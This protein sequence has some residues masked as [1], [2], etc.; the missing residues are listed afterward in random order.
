MHARVL[1]L[2]ACG[3]GAFVVPAP[4][5]SRA[6][7][8]RL[9]APASVHGPQPLRAAALAEEL[10]LKSWCESNGVVADK[11]AF[12]DGAATATQ[13]VAAL[14]VLARVPRSLALSVPRRRDWAG[15]LTAEA[16]EAVEAGGPLASYV[17]SWRGGGWA[18]SSEDL[19]SRDRDTVDCLLATGSDNDFEI[20]KKFG[21]KCHPAV[22]R[23]AYRLAAICRHPDEK[24][25]RVAQYWND[26]P[27]VMR[28]HCED[29]DARLEAVVLGR[30]PGP[31]PPW[32]SLIGRAQG[33]W[34][35]G[36]IL[37]TT[38]GR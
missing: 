11:L 8:R 9:L 3:A 6:R 24:A 10:D 37:E 36:G 29:C 28:A 21:M 38:G 12:D 7:P 4:A 16:I 23:A 34:W 2:I 15:A 32:S 26:L 25:A 30:D 33:G 31:P 1:L 14:E 35:R 18:T 19:E 13:N 5:S 17:R 27:A 22:D 20:F